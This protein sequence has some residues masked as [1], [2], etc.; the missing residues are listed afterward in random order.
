MVTEVAGGNERLVIAGDFA[1]TPDELFRYWTDPELLTQWW[2]VEAEI[3]PREGGTYL[4]SWPRME[5]RLR[6]RYTAFEPGKRLTFTWNW[7][8]EPDTP[9]RQVDVLFEP[10][11]DGTQMTIIHG[12]YT[13]SPA[14]QQE[15]QGHL[16]GW[17]HFC[18]RLSDVVTT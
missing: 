12:P 9:E 15:R 13:D 8:H 11:G 1:K 2:P 14:D 17:Q 16:E 3:D 5:W 18:S 7:D 6:G 4:A 10:S